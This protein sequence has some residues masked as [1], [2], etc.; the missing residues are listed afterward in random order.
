MHSFGPE[1]YPPTEAVRV[2]NIINTQMRQIKKESGADMKTCTP[3]KKEII[4]IEN[5][6]TS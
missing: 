3:S 6:F 2:N 4:S 5:Y 1:Q